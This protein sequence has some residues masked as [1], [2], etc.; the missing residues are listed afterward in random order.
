MRHSSL[1]LLALSTMFASAACAAPS[2]ESENEEASAVSELK[3]Y[4][5][6]AKQLDLGDL[7]RTVVGFAT[8]ELDV[9]VANN[10]I[11]ARFDPPQV[12]AA[13]AEPNRVLPN[14]AE[15]KALDTVVSGL[16]ARFGEK[17]LGTEVNA[18]R[19]KHLQSGA[20][21]YYVESAFSAR[22]GLGRDWSFQANGLDD[23][24]VTLG[25]D[26]GAEL[27]SRLIVAAP[28][29]KIG[30]LVSAPLSAAKQMRGFVY[31]RSV[32]DVRKMKPGEM[33]AL[34]GLG[35][36]GANFGVGAP[37]L[38][39]EP[40]G[41]LAYR[42]VVSAGVSGVIGG[43]LDVQLVRLDGDEV[44]VDVGVENGKGVSFHA[45]LK[46]GWGVKGICDDGERCLRKVD[47]GVGQVDLSRLVEKAIE[48]R[49]NSYLT[50]RVEGQAASA[51]SR[52]SLSR[53][54]FHLDAGNE[55]EVEKALQQA[56]KFDV[57]FAQALYN[58]DLGERSP[59][60]VAEF[61]AV[62][63]STT[64]TRSFGFELLGMNVYHRAVVKNEGSFVV[65]TPEGAKSILFDSVH[66]D[67]GW[68]QMDHG[69][70]RTGV[71]AQTLDAANPDRFKSEANLFLQTA[72]GDKHMDDD[73]IIDNVDALILG[74][75]GKEG[76]DVLDQYGNQM[77]RLVWSRC[78]AESDR[79]GQTKKFDEECNV[80][81]LEDPA[82]T[83][84]KAKG[85][86]AFD[87]LTRDLPADFQ[88]MVREAAKVRLTLQSVGIHNF[89]AT[90]GPN[91]SFTLDVR[92]DD[93]ALSI[94]T[95][96][97]KDQFTASVREYL[98]AVYA[99]RMKV[100][101]GM[102]KA[103]AL[104]AVDDK[105]GGDIA[106]MA[107]VFEA[108]SKAYQALV[109]TERRMLN[110]LSG[111]RF[112]SYP[113]GLRFSVDRSESK[114]YESAIVDST[115]HERAKAASRLFD[116]LLEEAARINAPLYDEHTAAFPLLSLVPRENLEVGMSV[117]ADARSTFW[118]K[119]ERYQKAGFTSVNAK[120]RGAEVSTIRAGMFDLDA[121]IAGK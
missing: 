86:A 71:A 107:K 44:V 103:A 6:D 108:R 117:R 30:T 22:A 3:A 82:M 70:T 94:L 121:I 78:P 59:A 11:G 105:W 33:F 51:S 62:R 68:F 114:T 39:A 45:A 115:S 2:D 106:K 98:A 52:V 41:G 95:S 24:A 91:A 60:V 66:K 27:V 100:G 26:A 89:D 109:E 110:A 99:D 49:L 63:A 21:K 73:I 90:N 88:K 80:R 93:K 9:S 57:R 5:A 46:D 20:D 12:F 102:D 16:A 81:L 55:D 111:K 56:L 83:D 64:S 113:L 50:F 58:R 96:K 10:R 67:G 87:A 42:I 79:Q 28:D 29:D 119:R 36:L 74:T 61:D 8:E 69:Y 32:S 18:A 37:L 97:T 13:K 118:G 77:Q 38:V 35:K 40:T 14:V 4:W 1:A 72:V 116:G 43:Q 48:K 17:E 75:V 47:L 85:I 112:V 92:F 15:I 25:F 76:V 19:L 53:F 65:Q 34:R 7:R 101:A 104:A 23:V 120:A 31:P 84:L 54:R